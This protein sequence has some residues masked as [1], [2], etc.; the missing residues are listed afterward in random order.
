VSLHVSSFNGRLRERAENTL[1]GQHLLWK[2]ITFAEAPYEVTE[3]DKTDN[4]D[5]VYLTADS[6]NTIETLEPG[7]KYIIG[8]IV[9]RNRHKVCF[10]SNN[11]TLNLLIS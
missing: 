11:F 7:K 10:F 3:K 6:D 4:G 1:K 2:E 5:L 9:D 8:G